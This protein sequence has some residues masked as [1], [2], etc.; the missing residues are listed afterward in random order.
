M[1]PSGNASSPYDP[2]IVDAQKARQSRSD[3]EFLRDRLQAALPVLQLRLLELQAQEYSVQWHDEYAQIEAECHALA[4]EMREVYR[5]VQSKLVDVLTRKKAC[6]AEV[7]RING[8]APAGVAL[9]LR[10]V[11][12]VARNLEGFTR[13]QPSI[14]NEL[15]L[16]DW[17]Q[18]VKLAW[19]PPQTALAVLAVQGMAAAVDHP[20]GN[21]WQRRD[22]RQR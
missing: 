13:D 12:L 17:D 20:G 14:T 8:S 5:G 16:P 21:W 19:P 4:T 18:P 15:Q 22:E 3:A 9:R 2:T 6:D 1:P 7:S 10:E 11:E